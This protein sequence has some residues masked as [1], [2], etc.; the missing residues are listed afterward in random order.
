MRLL[1][2]STILPLAFVGCTKNAS[3]SKH[4]EY[5]ISARQL[6][7]FASSATRYD[8]S[9][10]EI[11]DTLI[12][13]PVLIFNLV[14]SKYST[15]CIL[16]DP[17]L[18]RW[19]RESEPFLMELGAGRDSTDEQIVEQIFSRKKVVWVSE[20]DYT[21]KILFTGLPDEVAH[22]LSDLHV[23]IVGR[24]IRKAEQ[25]EANIRDSRSKSD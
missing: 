7:L 11:Y 8:H 22:E 21:F 3:S 23:V 17:N 15:Q 19:I 12:E 25:D 10:S 9:A 5:I 20:S 1:L 2:L 16:N 24:M 6:N 4:S 14:A 18:R 13:P